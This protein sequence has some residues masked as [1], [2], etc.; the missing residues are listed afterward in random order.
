M[1]IVKLV[2]RVTG[3]FA[4]F[5]GVEL[6][7]CVASVALDSFMSSSEAVFGVTIVF[8]FYLFPITFAVTGL[9]FSSVFSLVSVVDFV[10]T[11]AGFWGIFVMFIGVAEVA[12]DLFVMSLEREFGFAVVKDL[13]LTPGF[14]TVTVC[15]FFAQ[16]ALVAIIGFVAVDAIVWCFTVGFARF[17]AG[18]TGG[19]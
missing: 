3:L 12:F 6:G 14:F 15:A 1:H 16:L 10:T 7:T 5:L 11:N 2:A 18:V 8:E 4:F 17:V 13:L 9:A 19:F